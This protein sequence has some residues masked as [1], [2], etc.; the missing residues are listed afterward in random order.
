M[1]RLS[2]R[3]LP[4]AAAALLASPALAA[5]ATVAVSTTADVIAAD[6]ACSLREATIAASTNTPAAAGPGECAAG[7]TSEDRIVVPA[8]SYLL[9][10]PRT[11]DDE[12]ASR[13]GDLDLAGAVVVEGAGQAATVIDGAL[14]DR[15]LDVAAGGSARLTDLTVTGGLAPDGAEAPPLITIGDAIVSAQAPDGASGGGIRNLGSL[16]LVRVTVRGNAA[17]RGGTG[18]SAV[19]TGPGGDARAGQGGRG[20]EGGGIWSSGPLTIRESLITGNRSG[21]GGV[22]G[23][24]VAGDGA[25]V[26]GAG[27]GGPGGDATGGDGGPGGDG[28][29]ISITGIGV[30][31]AV[32]IE[33]SRVSG[34]RAGPFSARGTA[35]AGKGGAGGLGAGADGRAE[36]G[37]LGSGG[38]GGGVSADTAQLRISAALIDG[39]TGYTLGGGVFA[40]FAG[41]SIVN[42]TFT[43]NSAPGGGGIANLGQPGTVRFAT[44]VGNTGGVGSGTA[45]GGGLL[46]VTG[47]IIDGTCSG[48][49]SDGGGN[50]NLILVAG[51]QCPGSG[52]AAGA[53]SGLLAANGGLLPTLRPVAGSAAIDH[54]G[55]SPSCPT[56]D[57]R[58][59][60]R[61][62]GAGCDAGAVELAPPTAV[63]STPQSVA[64]TNAVLAG[65][66]RG[67][68]LA[69]RA[70]F[71]FGPTTAYGRTTG[72]DLGTSV[73]PVAV[74]A[75]ATGLAPG[76][77]YHY[78]LVVTTPDGVARGA[79]T[80]FTTPA[81][82]AVSEV[83]SGGSAP[84]TATGPVD[85]TA[86][87]VRGL[88]LRP[89]RFA[90][91][92]RR[93]AA[94]RPKP[95]VGSAFLF[96]L[97]EAATVDVTIVRVIRGI[98]R[99]GRCVVRP[100]R[101]RGER[102]ERTVPAG[103][104]RLAGAAGANTVPFSG[105][106]AGK[107]LRPADYRV[108]VTSTDAAGNDS[109]P[110]RA[111]FTVLR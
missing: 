65:T 73:N 33:D 84:A 37:S 24:A 74:T 4:L 22:G 66:A 86:P 17:G 14:I 108:T 20:G 38:R 67:F 78:R 30:N 32:A 7:Q 48:S 2:P 69:G 72:A 63:T 55:S 94:G 50:L 57:A 81:G 21:V 19:S 5:A 83:P 44:L 34:N 82:L 88:A 46:T 31:P 96:R 23:N 110:V 103:R 25:D 91:T 27:V 105:R 106:I 6:G 64:P 93:A 111:G 59:A 49:P 80:V 15:V 92:G 75:T 97:S 39:N 101:V 68:G 8:G 12:N 87:E 56:T 58:G 1:D 99:K 62:V 85:R 43:G 60:A 95:R 18:R 90:V 54:A 28:G 77:T 26:G 76:T 35:S 79:D 52:A 100:A 51:Q 89:V 102:C 13:E 42:S 3:L 29:G 45:L 11:T 47:S 109:P 71:E 98:R 53:T 10:V 41:P 36:S 40:S 70:E 9:A 16:T 107:A 61:P 104:L